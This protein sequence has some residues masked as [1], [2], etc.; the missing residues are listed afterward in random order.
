MFQP[1]SRFEKWLTLQ[2]HQQPMT[3]RCTRC[4]VY[5]FD[6]I[7]DGIRA[8]RKRIGD[9]VP[10]LIVRQKPRYN[11]AHWWKIVGQECKRELRC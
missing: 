9:F 2:S 5:E 3:G 11:L 7:G 10:R 1:R 8:N 4:P 6:V